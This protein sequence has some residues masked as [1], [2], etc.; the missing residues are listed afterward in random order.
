MRGASYVSPIKNPGVDSRAWHGG[1]RSR[2]AKLD[3]CTACTF[4]NTLPARSPNI[5]LHTSSLCCESITYA[6]QPVL[7]IPNVSNTPRSIAIRVCAGR[8]TVAGML[9]EQA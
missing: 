4:L 8:V 2:R 5:G 6:N 9:P 7:Q 1:L 3:H